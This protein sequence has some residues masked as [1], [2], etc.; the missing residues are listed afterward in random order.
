MM[1]SLD[2]RKSDDL[3]EVSAVDRPPLRR[4]LPER[5]MRPSAIVVAREVRKNPAKV[6]LVENDD[7]VQALA[8]K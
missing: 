6:P 8:T 4:V 3:S 5:Q 2:L 7:V 1:E